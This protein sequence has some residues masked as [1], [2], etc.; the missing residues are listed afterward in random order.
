MNPTKQSLEYSVLNLS[1]GHTRPAFPTPAPQWANIWPRS[2][3]NKFGW[4][5]TLVQP[6]ERDSKQKNESKVLSLARESRTRIIN[7]ISDH[8]QCV[9]HP[10]AML[11]PYPKLTQPHIVADTEWYTTLP[12]FSLSRLIY[13]L[14]PFCHN[15]GSMRPS[16]TFVLSEVYLICLT[17]CPVM[18]KELTLNLE[19]ISLLT[20]PI[21]YQTGETICLRQYPANRSLKMQRINRKTFYDWS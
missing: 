7:V 13:V 20:W 6:V 15:F 16:F 12:P 18:W 10:Q 11:S 1:E 5:D 21:Q 3:L 19:I 17:V 4:P 8:H 9:C 2:T 14:K